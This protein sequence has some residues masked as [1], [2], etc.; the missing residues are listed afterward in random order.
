MPL[1]MNGETYYRTHEVCKMA[2]ISKSTLFRW[3]KDGTDERTERD[4]R[5][6]R[7]FNDTQL[8]LIKSKTARLGGD[9]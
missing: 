1:K 8:K 7:L 2:G 9:F 3:L 4:W 6:W 5:G